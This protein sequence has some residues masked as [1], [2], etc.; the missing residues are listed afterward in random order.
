MICTN[1]FQ[2]ELHP[3]KTDLSITVDRT[4][5]TLHGLDCDICPACGEITFTH[6]QSLQVDKVRCQAL[7]D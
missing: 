4:D 3:G 7:Q 5:Q 1:C 6:A 2:A